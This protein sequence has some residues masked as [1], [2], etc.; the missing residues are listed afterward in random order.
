MGLRRPT[1]RLTICLEVII[2]AVESHIVLQIGHQDLGPDPDHQ[3]LVQ[4]RIGVTLMILDIV[5]SLVHTAVHL[6]VTAAV[7]PT[8]VITDGGPHQD[9]IVVTVIV[10]DQVQ[11]GQVAGLTLAQGATQDL[12]HDH[13]QGV[14]L[15]VQMGDRN[16]RD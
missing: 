2:A 9:A 6:E 5:M 16:L 14:N 13:V 4:A 12:S 3:S 15:A 11:V 7:A 10:A 1:L 8:I